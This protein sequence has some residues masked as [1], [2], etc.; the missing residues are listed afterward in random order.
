MLWGSLLFPTGLWFSGR[1]KFLSFSAG[2]W[3]WPDGVTDSVSQRKKWRRN[4]DGMGGRERGGERKEEDKK[5]GGGEREGREGEKR[6]GEEK[7]R[8][9][10]FE[11]V[12]LRMIS[13]THSPW[14]HYSTVT[15]SEGDVSVTLLQHVIRRDHV[16]L[17]LLQ[18]YF[19]FTSDCYCLTVTHL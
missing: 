6:G 19:S 9:D 5:G 7:G 3:H 1:D 18:C 4:K 14:T 16:S 11:P 8:G 13:F 12:S 15:Y 17:T 2:A 10:I